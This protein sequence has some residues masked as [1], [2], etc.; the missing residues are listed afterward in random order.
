MNKTVLTIVGIF[1]VGLLILYAFRGATTGA[2]T[3]GE[4]GIT[5]TDPGVAKET[6]AA[7]QKPVFL[8]VQTDWC[9]FCRKMKAE[10]FADAAVQKELNDRFVNITINPEKDGTARF[11][12]QELSYAALAG[13]LGVNGYPA[14]FFFTPDGKLLGGQPGYIEPS[15]FA[16]LTEYIG[17]GF[18][19]KYKFPEF[20]ALP[21]DKRS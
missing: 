17:G 7:T 9:T 18:Y 13:Q 4:Q 10:T 21:K 1:A 16:D 6:I 11:T 12:G 14:S 19:T 20:Q 3:G 5:W 8:F 2:A 15:L